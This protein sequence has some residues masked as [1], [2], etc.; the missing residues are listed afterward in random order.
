VR[1]PRTLARGISSPGGSPWGTAGNVSAV[2]LPT[3][4]EIDRILGG[5]PG[6]VP[7]TRAENE[8]VILAAG[9]AVF[10]VI[11]K[12]LTEEL[13]DHPQILAHIHSRLVGL[14]EAGND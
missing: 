2:S 1:G 7:M 4:V 8:A 10:A 12:V 14:K 5:G 3:D 6:M 11:N 13:R 9:R